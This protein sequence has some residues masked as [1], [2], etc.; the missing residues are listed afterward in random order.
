MAKNRNPGRKVLRKAVGK[1]SGYLK[2]NI[3]R[4][5][6]ML[7]VVTDFPHS[8]K[9]QKQFWVVQTLY[10]Q[11]LEMYSQHK[12]SVK[13][14]IVGIHQPHVRPMV[15]KKAGARVEFG[16]WLHLSLVDG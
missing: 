6:Q 8:K 3:A 10:G 4:I 2:R 7:D 13:D 11:Q 1:Q 5:Y 15:R 14:R 9:L 12:H 16:S